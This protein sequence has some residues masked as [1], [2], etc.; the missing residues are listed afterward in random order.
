M[1]VSKSKK[2]G[3][4][5]KANFPSFFVSLRTFYRIVNAFEA[6]NRTVDSLPFKLQMVFYLNSKTW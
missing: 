6:K 4:K 1:A 5:R 3:K 2:K